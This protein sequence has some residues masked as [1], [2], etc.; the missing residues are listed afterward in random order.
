MM[1]DIRAISSIRQQAFPA[2]D[3]EGAVMDT[4]RVLRRKKGRGLPA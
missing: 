4:A 2:A 1:A 3:T